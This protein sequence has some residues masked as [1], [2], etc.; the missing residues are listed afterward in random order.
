VFTH[1][2]DFASWHN[3]PSPITPIKSS[4]PHPHK[5]LPSGLILTCA[6]WHTHITLL[7]L[8]PLLHNVPN[9]YDMTNH[10]NFPDGLWKL[11][12]AW[13]KMFSF[14]G[15]ENWYIIKFFCAHKHKTLTILSLTAG[16]ISSALCSRIL[17]IPVAREWR[18]FHNSKAFFCHT[19]CGLQVNWFTRILVT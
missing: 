12:Q 1:A 15:D 11:I 19:F 16:N 7:E 10:V 18:M 5:C 6:T 14:L 13:Q 8:I 9:C 2:H 4:K 3:K 17:G